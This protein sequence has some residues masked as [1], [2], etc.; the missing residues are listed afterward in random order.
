VTTDTS[1]NPAPRASGLSDRG[2]TWLFITPTMLLLLGIT[3]FPL[4]WSLYLSFTNFS[5]VRN[6]PVRWVGTA[7]YGRL[8]TNKLVWNHFVVTANFVVLSVGFEMLLGFGL[9][10]LLNRR[11][12]GRGLVMTLM[13]MPMMLPPIVVGLFWN[14]IYRP[15]VGVI[16]YYITQVFK[17]PPV[18][19]L[20]N[21]HLALY[22][23]VIVDIWMWTPFVMLIA[24]AGLSAIPRYLYEAADVDRASTWFKFRHITL[25]MVWPLLL[26]ALLFRTMDAFKMFDQAF[27]LTGGGPGSSTE[28]VSLFL[29]QVAF[30]RFNTGEA[31]ALGYIIL[32]IIIALSNL[33]IRYLNKARA[34]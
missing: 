17:L 28:T 29:Y 22:S 20:T 3:V 11:F 26:I 5:A 12:P 13:L 10:L 7:N 30:R 4:L 2:M 27:I 33:Y 24:L 6:T 32:I 18:E 23:I 9:A 14:F 16:N 15:D 21:I 31:S 1:P 8:L 25:P 19:W 34:G